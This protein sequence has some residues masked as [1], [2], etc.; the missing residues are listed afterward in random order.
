MLCYC[1]VAGTEFFDSSAKDVIE[2]IDGIAVHGGI[3]NNDVDV[4]DVDYKKA[5]R[6]YV[7][8]V[9]DLNY[10]GY[11]WDK[12][13]KAASDAS[14]AKSATTSLEFLETYSSSEQSVLN[15]PVRFHS[16][17]YMDGAAMHFAATATK[18]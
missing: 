17:N 11:D 3:A 13:A 2:R 5:R 16:S 18:Q 4:D 6:H 15:T 10:H 12:G 14:T 8:A 9:T 7:G 1:V